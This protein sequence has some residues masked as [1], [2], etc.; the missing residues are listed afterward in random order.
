MRA[1]GHCRLSAM[2]STW[3]DT[4]EVSTDSEERLT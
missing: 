2:P 3:V 1:N 4:F